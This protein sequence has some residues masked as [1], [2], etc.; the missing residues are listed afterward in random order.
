MM[1]QVLFRDKPL[2]RSENLS[3]KVWNFVG[4]SGSSGLI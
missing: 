4:M 1:A 2:R 3:G